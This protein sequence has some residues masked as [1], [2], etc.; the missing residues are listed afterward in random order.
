MMYLQVVPYYNT[1]LKQSVHIIDVCVTMTIDR[2]ERLALCIIIV[3]GI[4]Y[5][6]HVDW[7]VWVLAPWPGCQTMFLKTSSVQ[8]RKPL[9]S[10]LLC[11]KSVFIMTVCYKSL[12][13]LHLSVDRHRGW[14]VSN[15]PPPAR[16]GNLV[17]LSRRNLHAWI[18]CILVLLLLMFFPLRNNICTRKICWNFFIVSLSL[19]ATT[20]FSCIDI[21]QMYF[22]LANKTVIIYLCSF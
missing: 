10:T 1:G 6:T 5:S 19:P 14:G 15:S 11:M 13:L 8:F 2:N 20:D 7:R 4:N 16:L 12:L 3:S 9:C 18:T 17:Y 21:F 22:Y